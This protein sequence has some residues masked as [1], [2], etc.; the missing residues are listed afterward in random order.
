MYNTTPTSF[1]GL[2]GFFL[3]FIQLLVPLIFAA[4]FLVIAWG[5]IK[6]WVINGGDPKAAAAGK[7]I[8][9][10]G[11]IALVFMFGVWGLVYMLQGSFIPMGL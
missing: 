6:A 4:T 5:V 10:V 2:V 8:A 3:G 7:Q 1:A 9:F 11:V